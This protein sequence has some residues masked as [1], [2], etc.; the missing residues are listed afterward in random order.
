MGAKRGLVVI[1][2]NGTIAWN[3]VFPAAIDPGVD[4]VLTALEALNT[5]K[6]GITT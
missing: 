6:E 4:G 3:A 1:D 2:T 5:L